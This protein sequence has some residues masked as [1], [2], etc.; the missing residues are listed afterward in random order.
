MNEHNTASKA[1]LTMLVLSL[2]GGSV[3]A[4]AV[5]FQ[6]TSI[7]MV[8]K[9]ATTSD[10]PVAADHPALAFARS[11]RAGPPQTTLLQGDRDAVVKVLTE[12]KFELLDGNYGPEADADGFYSEDMNCTLLLGRTGPLWLTAQKGQPST[13]LHYPAKVVYGPY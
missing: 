3:Q 5:K 10:V 9:D 1:L 6:A 11:V 13:D 8:A 7:A 4:G 2:L 12:A